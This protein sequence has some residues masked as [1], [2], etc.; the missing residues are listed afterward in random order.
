[1]EHGLDGAVIDP[2][3]PFV[4]HLEGLLEQVEL[5]MG[6]EY[7]VY[8]VRKERGAELVRFN[9]GVD[10]KDL[11]CGLPSKEILREGRDIDKEHVRDNPVG[12]R[13]PARDHVI[14][15]DLHQK[16]ADGLRH[17]VVTEVNPDIHPLL[18]F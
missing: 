3:L 9:A 7:P 1:V 6:R 17:Q 18:P 15:P 14:V 2:D 5:R 10:E 16:L 11:C 13:A 8:P 4:D 12:R